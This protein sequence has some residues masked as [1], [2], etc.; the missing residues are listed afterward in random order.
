MGLAAD[1]PGERWSYRSLG[2][3]FIRRFSGVDPLVV[4]SAFAGVLA[5]I[6]ELEVW[7]GG[8]GSQSLRAV[9]AL[10]MT[11][12]LALRR[13]FPLPV[14]L[15][16]MGASLAQSVADPEADVAG[17]LVVAIIAVA[18][19]VAAHSDVPTA[20]AGGLAGLGALWA[21]VRLQG[22]G[23]G[24]YIFA[25]R[26][27]RGRLARRIHLA[28]APAAYRGARK[29]GRWRSSVTTRSARGRRSPRSGRG[30]P[31]TCTTP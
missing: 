24:N 9:V 2:M 17:V 4:D 6:A 22:G 19:S 25:G 11:L 28:L 3:R 26:D 20:V 5:V 23:V 1:A 13:R 7:S 16:V 29:T 15:L 27:L 14:L 8:A 21:S 30:S 31:V 18:Y 10:L 12:P